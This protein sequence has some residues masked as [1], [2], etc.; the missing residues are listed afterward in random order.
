MKRVIA[1]LINLSI[2]GTLGTSAA[3]WGQDTTLY[4]QGHEAGAAP[5]A[6]PAIEQVPLGQ[7]PAAETP[8]MERF[9]AAL[10]PHGRWVTTPEYGTVWV[11]NAAADP[12]WRPYSNGRWAYTEHGW[13][14]VAAEP[15][16][17]APF[18]YG[19]WL[20]Y[21]AYGWSWLPGYQWAPAWV[22]WRYGG[23][24]MAW[25]P[26]GP[27][28]VAAA[29]YGTPSLWMAVGGRH[30]YRPLHRS[31]FVP[32]VR[33]YN[34]FNRTT[35]AGVPR[36]RVYY[37]PPASYV[38]RV[39]GVPVHRISSRAVA[40]RWVPGS[41]RFVPRVN[42]IMRRSPVVATPR[43]GAVRSWPSRPTYR[44]QPMRPTYR[45]GWQRPGYQRPSYSRP[46]R[47]SNSYRPYAPRP[48]FRPRPVTP[49]SSSRKPLTTA[50][51]SKRR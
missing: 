3:A 49:P 20:Y 48:S 29:Y 27:L 50:T 34:V 18:H 46:V 33:I 36:G 24:Y 25:A 7:G 19:R 1:F 43:G 9:Q 28:G 16:G 41:G 47:P 10:S 15:W 4:P 2:I 35:F 11:P 13:T 38:S 14:F 21:P 12:S 51:R 32:T 39:S 23:G 22:A 44:P 30:F 26:L 5:A 37:S 40:P 17:W 31:Y 6:P 8:T 45:P 42:Q